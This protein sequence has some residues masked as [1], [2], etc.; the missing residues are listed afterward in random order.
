LLSALAVHQ[1]WLDSGMR[2]I[3][4]YAVL[5]TRTWAGGVSFGARKLVDVLPLFLPALLSATRAVGRRNAAI[6]WAALVVLLAAPTVGLHAAA[7]VDPH[8]TTGV[9]HDWESLRQLLVL[10]LDPDAWRAALDQRALPV[11]VPVIL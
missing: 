7:F 9:V 1:V 8:R 5:G 11:P 2:D 4:P 10:P 6:P 3:E